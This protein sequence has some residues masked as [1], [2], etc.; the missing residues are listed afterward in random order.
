MNHTVAHIDE[1]E[2]TIEHNNQVLY[3]LDARI[4]NGTIRAMRG[5]EI[6]E[7][8]TLI[9]TML[10]EDNETC[11]TYMTFLVAQQTALYILSLFH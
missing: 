5:E 11:R 1:L 2:K 9:S 3:N 4:Y 8:H 10:S 7:F 6:N